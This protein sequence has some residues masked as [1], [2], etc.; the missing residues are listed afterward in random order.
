VEKIRD[1]VLGLFGVSAFLFFAAFA[2]LSLPLNVIAIMRLQGWSWLAAMLAAIVLGAIPI[3]GQLGYLV[4]TVLGAYYLYAANFDWRD[5]VSRMPQTISFQ[6]L[7]PD[8]FSALKRAMSDSIAKECK[9]ELA[10]RNN[11]SGRLLPRQADVCDCLARVAVRKITAA[12][13]TTFA[14]AKGTAEEF[15]AR[16]KP[17]IQSECS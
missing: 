6:Q 11:L 12:D 8:E 13:L 3:I 1:F 14:N 4:L 9:Q 16:M 15:F 5:A 2:L 10:V 17:E 7:S